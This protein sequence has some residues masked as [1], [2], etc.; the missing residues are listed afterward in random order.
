MKQVKSYIF[1]YS[2]ILPITL[3]ISITL[4]LHLSI[5]NTNN[6]EENNDDWVWLSLYWHNWVF[7][8]RS[9]LILD[10]IFLWVRLFSVQYPSLAPVGASSPLARY[11]TATLPR[12][13]RA[14]K[15]IKPFN[16]SDL[17]IWSVSLNKG[18][19][20]WKWLNETTKYRLHTHIVKVAS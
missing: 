20:G 7:V 16:H 1:L 13:L 4:N 9:G 6:S 10:R 18:W 19:T 11:K 17:Q 14:M 8:E 2:D 12:I 15:T 3:H 5:K